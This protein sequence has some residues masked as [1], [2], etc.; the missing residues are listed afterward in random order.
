LAV[1][2]SI[3]FCRLRLKLLLPTILTSSLSLY[4]YQK[5]ERALPGYPLT[6]CFLLPC[7]LCEFYENNRVVTF[8][9]RNV[10][11]SCSCVGF[12]VLTSVKMSMF[13]FWV[14]TPCGLVG[15]YHR[16]GETYHFHLQGSKME[17]VYFSLIS[18]STY[19]SVS[20]VAQLI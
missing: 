5:D 3:I 17:V 20:R 14:V 1:E 10:Y 2:L 16:F 9:C 19:K 12:E 8:I 7:H 18:V 15:R 4:P 13:V 11:N 6:R